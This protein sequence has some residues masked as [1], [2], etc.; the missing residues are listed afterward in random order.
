MT[1]RQ[2]VWGSNLG[3]TFYHFHVLF[4]KIFIITTSSM[5]GAGNDINYI[6]SATGSECIPWRECV[7]VKI[8][9]FSFALQ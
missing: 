6:Y 1:V 9:T 4:T 5:D 2:R 7:L 8:T 3:K